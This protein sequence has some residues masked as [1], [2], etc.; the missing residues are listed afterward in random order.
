MGKIII[1]FDFFKYCYILCIGLWFFIII[2]IVYIFIKVSVIV[3]IG[4]IFLEFLFGFFFWYGV[5]GFIVLIGIFIV[6][7]GMKGVMIFLVI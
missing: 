2:L 4:G 1:M 6:L 7:S 5:I 3:Y